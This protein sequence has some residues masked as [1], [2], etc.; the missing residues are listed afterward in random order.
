MDSA[1]QS[2]A[3]AILVFFVHSQRLMMN[4]KEPNT[5][6]ATTGQSLRARVETRKAEIEAAVARPDLDK[7]VRRDLD[8]ALSEV[9]GL[10]TGDLDNIPKVVAAQ[11]NTWLEANKHLDERHPLAP[12]A[13]ADSQVTQA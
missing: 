4:D 7:R 2:A 10:L 5:T 6:D 13:Q 9:G 12:P 8:V 1:S 3:E 11:L